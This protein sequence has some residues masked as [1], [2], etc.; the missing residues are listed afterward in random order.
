MSRV[1]EVKECGDGCSF[2]S[3]AGRWGEP[4]RCNNP[5]CP[6]RC[7]TVVGKGVGR[8]IN[9]RYTSGFPEFCPLGAAT[10]GEQA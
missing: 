9:K 4:A 8:A 1:I 10:L 2:Y 3:S 6:K 7:G 5:E